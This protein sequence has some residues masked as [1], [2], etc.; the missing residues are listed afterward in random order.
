M[1][2]VVYANNCQHGVLLLDC[3]YCGGA[4][5]TGQRNHFTLLDTETEGE[6]NLRVEVEKLRSRVVSLDACV[7]YM[8]NML[9]A[10]PF[11]QFEL[12]AVEFYMTALKAKAE[13]VGGEE[14]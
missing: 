8:L 6:Q 10:E 9:T 7:R 14:A 2:N 11:E 13:P 1:S 5:V 3:Y 4:S 12:A